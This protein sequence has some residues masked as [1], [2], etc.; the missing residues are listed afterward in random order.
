M[1][2]FLKVVIY[3]IVLCLMGLSLISGTLIEKGDTISVLIGIVIF[4]IEISLLMSG[5]NNFMDK[6]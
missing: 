5:I 4:T 2:T 3:I 1:E 6:D